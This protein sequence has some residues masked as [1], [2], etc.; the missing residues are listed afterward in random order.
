[1]ISQRGAP[2]AEGVR[3]PIIAENC[4][5]MKTIWTERGSADLLFGQI[6][7][8]TAWKREKL[9]REG[10]A[11]LAHPIGSATA[12]VKKI[13]T[14]KVAT[15]QTLNNVYGFFFTNSPRKYTS[16]VGGRDFSANW[17]FMAHWHRAKAKAK[18]F[19]DVCRLFFYPFC[20]FFDLF[21]FR[22]RFRMVWIGP[23]I[24]EKVKV[25]INLV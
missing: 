13:F 16:Q 23:Y 4:V 25:V 18:I 7:P 8:K 12:S 2:T 9:D 21:C 20:L 11:C 22:S 5:K 6:Y 1:M 24:L 10:E 3:Q 19:F 15:K 17:T 14:F